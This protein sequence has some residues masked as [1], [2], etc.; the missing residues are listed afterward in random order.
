MITVIV[1]NASL[2]VWVVLSLAWIWLRPQKPALRP[3]RRLLWATLAGC[4]LG[5]LSVTGAWLGFPSDPFGKIQLLTWTVFGHLPLYLAGL[6]VGFWKPYRVLATACVLTVMLIS[7]IGIDAFLIEPHWLQVRRVKISTAKL[8]Q[9][10]R[11]AVVADLQTDAPGPYEA[12]AIQQVMAAQP[13]LILMAG[14]YIHEW[15]RDAYIS[16]LAALNA[17]FKDAKLRA[18]LGVYAV[19]GN[20]DEPGLWTQVFAGL[21]VTTIEET[22]TLDLGSL[23]L[24][25]LALEDAFRA[26]LVVNAQTEATTTTRFHIVL[27]HSPNFSLGDIQADLLIAGHTHGGQVQLPFLGPI[28]TLSAVPRSWASGVTRIDAGKTLVVSRGVGMER[29]NAPRLRFL[30]RPEI[31]ILELLPENPLAH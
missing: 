24:T 11:V 16:D 14:D 3:Q 29:H 21:P 10:L 28:M 7:A 8:E 9:P 20:V 1:Y 17:L 22:E 27:G 13:D 26:N 18:P 23:V 4:G 25:G 31:I 5:A 19:R 15:E 30:C 6:A 2:L 12:R